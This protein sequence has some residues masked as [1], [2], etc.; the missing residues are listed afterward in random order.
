MVFLCAHGSDG[1]DKMVLYSLPRERGLGA[2]E[3][4]NRSDSGQL[5]RPDHKA[6]AASCLLS[7][8]LMA[9]FEGSQLPCDKDIQA[10][11]WRKRPRW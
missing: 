7:L 3:S 6:T 2:N 1:L 5:P 10:G 4:K 9:Y 11:V 8:S